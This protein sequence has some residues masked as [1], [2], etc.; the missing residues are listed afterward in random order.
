MGHMRHEA[1]IVTTRLFTE[2]GDYRKGGL[3]DINAFRESLKPE[4]RPL[5]VGPIQTPVNGYVSYAFMPDGS[6]EGWRASDD[7]DEAREAFKNLFRQRYDDGS[8][9]DDWAHV[10]LWDDDDRC[11]SIVEQH[12]GRED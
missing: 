9:A 7:A 1:V 8:S 5:V 3:P 12:P 2:T 10:V 11:A 6:K 4:L